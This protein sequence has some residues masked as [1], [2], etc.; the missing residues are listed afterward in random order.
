MSPIDK[1]TKMKPRNH[2]TQNPHS[3]YRKR[4]TIIPTPSPSTLHRVTLTFTSSSFRTNVK[5]QI[6][7]N[8]T[9]KTV[10]KRRNNFEN[11]LGQG[12]PSGR[13]MQ[14]GVRLTNYESPRPLRTSQQAET[15]KA[16]KNQDRQAIQSAANK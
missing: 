2:Q 14:T 13:P 16:Q 8:S 6:N 11:S 9:K 5:K 4:V 7:A 15:R 10:P 12:Q 1:N 3:N